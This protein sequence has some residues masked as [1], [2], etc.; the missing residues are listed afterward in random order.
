MKLLL[1][2]GN[3]RIKWAVSDGG[4]IIEHGVAECG[5]GDIDDFLSGSFLHLPGPAAVY[6]ANVGGSR[7]ED[8]VGSVSRRLWSLEPRF[9]RVEAEQFGVVNA[10]AEPSTLGIDRWLAML[11]A[12]Q[13]RRQAA[14]VVSCGTAVTIDAVDPQG[15]HLGGLIVPGPQLMRDALRRGTRGIRDTTAEADAGFGRSTAQCVSN[16]ITMAIA[17]L[18]HRAIAIL[19][20]R[21]GGSP[22]RLV[23]GGAAPQV[24]PLLGA[25]FDHDPLLVLRGL[26]LVA[27]HAD[28]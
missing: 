1:D 3:T 24:L 5:Q 15:R 12:W 10:Y 18:V 6:V 11:A 26:L 2:I 8:A 19:E 25:G 28:V 23:T 27:E 20:S 17:E 7:V 4:G 21:G 16:G 13:P 14:C 9:V 22:Q